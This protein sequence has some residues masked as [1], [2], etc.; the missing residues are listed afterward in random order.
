MSTSLNLTLKRGPS[1]WDER[2]SHRQSNWRAYGVAAGAVLASLATAPASEPAVVDG[3]WRLASPAR[4]CSPTDCRLDDQRRG[5]V[6][7]FRRSERPRRRSRIRRFI[8]GQ[9]SDSLFEGILA[10][11]VVSTLP[12]FASA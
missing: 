4:V 11:D 7:S 5:S 1:V 9:R 3:P 6:A 2:R 8:P 10:S 12:R